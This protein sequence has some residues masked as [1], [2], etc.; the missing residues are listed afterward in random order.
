MKI[1]DQQLSNSKKDIS[2]IRAERY[3]A[4]NMNDAIQYEWKYMIYLDAKYI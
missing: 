1:S 4:K 2:T 3:I